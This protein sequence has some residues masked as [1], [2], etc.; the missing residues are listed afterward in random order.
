[1]SAGKNKKIGQII[2]PRN[3]D[4]SIIQYT[5]DEYT[6]FHLTD[7]D[8]YADT[9]FILSN[10][11]FAL[12]ENEH[13]VNEFEELLVPCFKTPIIKNFSYFQNFL[14]VNSDSVFGRGSGSTRVEFNS[15]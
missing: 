10:K 15:R 11:S 8:R 13:F 3:S 6:V 2:R 5:N 1:M 12:D 9:K 14:S 7:C 4:S